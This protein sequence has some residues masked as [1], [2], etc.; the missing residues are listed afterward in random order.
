MTHNVERI[1]HNTNITHKKYGIKSF[2]NK[3]GQPDDGQG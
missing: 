2:N 1:T 3:T